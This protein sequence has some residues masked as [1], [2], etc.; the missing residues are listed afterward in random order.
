MRSDCYP[1]AMLI[2][3]LAIQKGSTPVLACTV[4]FSSFNVA[5]GSA[6][7][8]TKNIISF[9]V[10]HRLPFAAIINATVNVSVVCIATQTAMCEA[11]PRAISAAL[12]LS[13][14]RAVTICSGSSSWLSYSQ[15]LRL[16]LVFFT[17][18]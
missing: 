6:M 14:P 3:A 1:A 12:L 11:F 18:Y 4:Y 8:I 2:A 15:N 5:H 13:D 17:S 9:I 16:A 10:M 7:S